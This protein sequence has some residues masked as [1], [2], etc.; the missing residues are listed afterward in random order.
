MGDLGKV[1]HP[2]MLRTM[3]GARLVSAAA[4]HWER[5]RPPLH[6]PP[7]VRAEKTG[8]AFGFRP[9]IARVSAWV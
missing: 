4:T 7:G 9:L 2:A 3:T 5:A 1:A 6:R 8:Q